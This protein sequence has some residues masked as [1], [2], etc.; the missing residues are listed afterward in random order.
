M[1]ER[2]ARTPALSPRFTAALAT[3]AV[4]I[5]LAALLR[6]RLA[7]PLEAQARL[8]RGA[9]LLNTGNPVQAEQEWRTAAELAP[10]SASAY[11]ALGALYLSQ[12]GSVR[13][14]GRCTGWSTSNRASRTRCASWRR[15]STSASLGSSSCFTHTLRRCNSR[16]VVL[17]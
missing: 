6:G 5:L 15:L 17:R 10:K 8:F 13:P 16:G 3:L 11:R 2:S 12:A 14:V 7:T 9:D 1:V 4:L